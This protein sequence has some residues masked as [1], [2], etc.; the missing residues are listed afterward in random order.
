M[1]NDVSVIHFKKTT[2]AYAPDEIVKIQKKNGKYDYELI[3]NDK[4]K[5]IDKIKLALSQNK[6]VIVHFH[7]KIF[8]NPIFN[9]N[10]NIKKIIHYHSQPPIVQRTFPEKFI[11]NRKL[12][13]TQ[14]HCLLKEYKD[15]KIIR[16]FFDYDTEPV[17]NQTC[18]KIGYSPSNKGNSPYSDKGYKETNDIF[19]A[20]KTKYKDGISI[21]IITGKSYNECIR[22]KKDCHIIIDECKTGSFHKCTLEG[23]MLGCI[24]CVYI[25]SELQA[26]HRELYGQTLPIL[27]TSMKD[28]QAK[29]ESC[30]KMGRAQLQEIGKQN[31][32]TFMEY[33]NGKIVAEEFDE[34]YDKVL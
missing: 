14:Y 20:L 23:L 12:V 32:K 6:K 31:R 9:Q 22:L 10:P 18:I 13:L 11:I 30:I 4:K 5:V 34:I 24:V 8:D 33:W 21:Q 7:N 3:I 2:L 25:K 29:L 16:N 27:N 26:K 28:L 19:K 17:Y 15:C 1:V